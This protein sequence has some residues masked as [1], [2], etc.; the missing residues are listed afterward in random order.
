MAF[1]QVLVQ[2]R[3]FYLVNQRLIVIEAILLS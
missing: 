2:E 1:W 3:M